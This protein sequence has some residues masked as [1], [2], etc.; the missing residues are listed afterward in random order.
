M[1][2]SRSVALVLGCGEFWLVLVA[3]WGTCRWPLEVGFSQVLAVSPANLV[4]GGFS[5]GQS[6]DRYSDSVVCAVAQL[7]LDA[8][9]GCRLFLIG[10][11]PEYIYDLLYSEPTWKRNPNHE[12]WPL[13]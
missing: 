13:C 4:G 1:R 10:T 6:A 9:V 11:A 3:G 8:T 2:R 12:L 5:T 7:Y